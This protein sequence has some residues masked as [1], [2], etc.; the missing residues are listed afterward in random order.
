MEKNNKYYVPSYLIIY[1]IYIVY[2]QYMIYYKYFPWDLKPIK[3]YVDLHIISMQVFI[4]YIGAIRKKIVNR[5]ELF[6]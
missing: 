3:L 2:T 1:Y 4:F 6:Y 5:L